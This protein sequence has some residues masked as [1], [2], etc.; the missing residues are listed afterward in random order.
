MYA[1]EV[2]AARTI[3]INDNSNMYVVSCMYAHHVPAA[4]TYSKWNTY[5]VSH[6]YTS[7]T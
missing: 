5:V 7:S 2:S 6:V 3:I 1:H 4:K